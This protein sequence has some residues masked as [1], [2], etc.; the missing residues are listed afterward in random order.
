MAK[1]GLR[2][3]TFGAIY[4]VATVVGFGTHML[5]SLLSMWISVF[6]LIGRVRPQGCRVS[7]VWQDLLCRPAAGFLLQCALRES[8]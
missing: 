7:Q 1:F 2:I 4:V 6:T 5:I 8:C 3:A